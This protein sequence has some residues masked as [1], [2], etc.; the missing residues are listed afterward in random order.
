MNIKRYIIILFLKPFF[1][2]GNT[3][4]LN[5]IPNNSFDKIKKCVYEDVEFKYI[6]NWFI[7]NASTPDYFLKCRKGILGYSIPFNN[8]LGY[9]ESFDKDGYV[10]I[11][12]FSSSVRHSVKN[13]R[14][15]VEVKL[16]DTLEIGS[17]YII[18][19]YFS[20]ADTSVYAVT[21]ISFGFTKDIYKN[22]ES[23]YPNIPIDSL[24]GYV[25]IVDSFITDK[26]NWVKCEKIY[27]AK[28]G[29]SYLIIGNFRK[30]CESKTKKLSKT[31]TR[32]KS[33]LSYYY[34][35]NISIIR[36]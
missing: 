9:Q 13:Y 36:H 22:E 34:I 26:I 20:L 24:Y 29:E 27:V 19:A 21:P 35:D 16:K 30:D 31:G 12:V 3:D 2:L 10:G 18:S 33:I 28:G 32:N 23:I 8:D 11:Y 25:D 6:D 17:K 15:Y 1:I 7:P 14:E 5:F 4:S